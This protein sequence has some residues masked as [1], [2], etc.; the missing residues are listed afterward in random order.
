MYIF[1][2]LL[3]LILLIFELLAIIPLKIKVIV[4]SEELPNFCFKASWLGSFFKGIVTR[5]NNAMFLTVYSFNTKVFKK[6]LKNNSNGY[7][8]KLNFIKT[9]RVNF[10]DVKV[11]YGFQDPSITGMLCGAVDLVSSYINLDTLYNDFDF[12]SDHDYFNINVLANINMINLLVTIFKYNK[13]TKVSPLY[14]AK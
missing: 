8:D 7:I 12:Y 4:N 2:I 11:S 9:L 1:S 5:E 13:K 3:F 10:I 14:G 6:E